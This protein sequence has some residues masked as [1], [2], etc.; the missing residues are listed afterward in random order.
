MK[1]GDLLYFTLLTL[2]RQRFRS[3]ML[4]LSLGLGV[5]SVTLLVSL[6]EAARAYVLSEFSVLG[7]DV[8][9]VFPGRKTTTGGMPPVT[10]TAARD[11]TVEE[12]AIIKGTVKG[13]RAVAALVVGT[14]PVSHSGRERDVLILGASGDFFAMRQLTLSQGTDWSELDVD[15]IAPVAVIG[16]RLASAMFGN[17]PPVGRWLR[18]RDYRFRVAG[19]LAPGGDSFGADLSEAV[20]IP[21][22]SAQ[23]LFNTAGIF[24]LLVQTDGS[25]SRQEMIQ[26]LEA[27]MQA[28]HD[29]ELDVTIVSPDAMLASLGDI[30]RTTTLAVAAIAGISLLVAGVL[31]MN[32]TLISVQQRIPEIG[33]LKA[34]GA[35]SSQVRMI[36]VAEAVLLA[37]VASLIGVALAVAVLQLAQAA[38]PDLRFQLPVWAAL[39]VSVLTLIISVVFAWRPAY[40]AAAVSPVA[41]LG[42]GA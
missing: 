19:V 11:I 29:G 6:G 30:L 12:A 20:F 3:L 26:A 13:V 24:R 4:I 23:Q 28:L 38:L 37:L 15:Q 34:I 7:T 18:V 27:R 1:V 25:R 31:V 32:L 21:V 41:A 40:R 2:R 33:L 5:S 16:S 8:L 17:S 10:G 39:A 36:F 35:S 22:A 14:A 9:A 42:R